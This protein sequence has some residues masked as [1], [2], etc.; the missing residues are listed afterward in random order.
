MTAFIA[1]AF[2]AFVL[3]F[4]ILP[5][6]KKNK[7]QQQRV[8]SAPREA[9]DSADYS[10]ELSTQ[11][12]KGESMA[13]SPTDMRK[14]LQFMWTQ[15]IREFEQATDMQV[16]GIKIKRDEWDKIESLVI[17]AETPDDQE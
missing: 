1:I 10:I 11:K 15:H 7:R 16:V 6:I 14:Q 12:R 13:L 3:Y 9:A 17:K 5:N 2:V 8:R 4:L